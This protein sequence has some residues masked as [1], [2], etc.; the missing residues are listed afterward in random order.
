MTQYITIKLTY[1]ALIAISV[2]KNYL[3]TATEAEQYD[4]SDHLG[5]RIPGTKEAC[6]RKW[7]ALIAFGTIISIEY[8]MLQYNTLI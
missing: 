8:T 1:K 3:T 6:S 2:V 7:A 4:N 5:G